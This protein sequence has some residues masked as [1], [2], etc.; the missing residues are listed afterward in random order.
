MGGLK[1]RK[2]KI[3]LYLA[4]VLRILNHLHG[5]LLQHTMVFV[6]TV[7]HKLVSILQSKAQSTLS[8]APTVQK[9]T[10]GPSGSATTCYLRLILDATALKEVLIINLIQ[11]VSSVKKT[12]ET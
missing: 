10:S 8:P 5:K 1:T 4:K 7:K 2:S 3:D 6:N 11:I 9:G 12:K